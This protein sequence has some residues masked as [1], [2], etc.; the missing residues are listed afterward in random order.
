VGKGELNMEKLIKLFYAIG[1]II[2][3]WGTSGI[4]MYFLATWVMLEDA[5]LYTHGRLLWLVLTLF[6]GWIVV[7][8][9]AK[10]VAD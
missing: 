10:F 6:C 3:V 9:L 4:V 8:F 2:V 1:G 5:F 7:Y